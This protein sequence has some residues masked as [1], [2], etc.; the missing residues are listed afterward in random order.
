MINKFVISLNIWCGSPP[1]MVKGWNDL[2]TAHQCPCKDDWDP[3]VLDCVQSYDQ[4][5]C[6]QQPSMQLLFPM[7]DE[8]GETCPHIEMHTSHTAHTGGETIIIEEEDDPPSS[9]GT[10]DELINGTNVTLADLN[11][12]G[13][14]HVHHAYLYHMVHNIDAP[15]TDGEPTSHGP[16]C[17]TPME[18]DFKCIPPMDCDYDILQLRFARLQTDV[19][20]MT[21]AETTQHACMHACLSTPYSGS[22]TSLPI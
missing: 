20:K 12:S 8:H 3:S 22:T 18:C 15:F 2:A 14:R 1:H 10:K 4:D 17:I 21:L 11:Y 9:E 16:K 7:F 13:N 5:W 19:V 6:N